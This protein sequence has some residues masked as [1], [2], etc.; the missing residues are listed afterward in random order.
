MGCVR[1]SFA[2]L[3]PFQNIHG[4][5]TSQTPLRR[6]ACHS[7][8]TLF[9]RGRTPRVPREKKWGRGSAEGVD[10]ITENT[11]R[12]LVEAGKGTMRADSHHKETGLDLS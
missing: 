1:N 4:S 10:A 9:R 2:S 8:A 5:M 3:M 6:S 12:R 7:S 11:L